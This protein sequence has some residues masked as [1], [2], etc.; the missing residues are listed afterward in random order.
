MPTRFLTR[1]GLP[2]REVMHLDWLGIATVGAL[3]AWSKAQL[4]AFLGPWAESILRLSHGPAETEI[5]L[6]IPPEVVAVE[7][8]FEEPAFEPRELEPALRRLAELAAERLAG[9]VARRVSVRAVFSGVSVGNTRLT[10]GPVTTAAAV[11]SALWHLR[12][13]RE[14]AQ[15]IVVERLHRG[16]F[17]SVEAFHSRLALPAEAATALARAGAFDGLLPRREALYRLAALGQ[18]APSGENTLLDGSPPAPPLALLTRREEFIWD[19][20]SYGFSTRELHPL[21][22]IRDRLRELAALPLAQVR[23]RGRKSRVRTAGLVVG[24]QKP[25][26]A[27]GFA[28]F[29]IEDGPVR[30]Q[31]ILSPRLWEENRS[32]LR[33]ASV[34]VVEGTVKETASQLAIKPELVLRLPSPV[35]VRGYHY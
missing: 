13:R 28:F 29:I 21:D 9:R 18:A 16:P 17:A 12:E 14:A 26:T 2:Q 19:Y 34:L 23:K 22:L 8:A 27:K 3:S 6:Y 1:S 25:A 15:A 33:D 7:C 20:R 31:L 24:R 32:L 10:K 35:A 5:P 11:Q 4:R 30:A